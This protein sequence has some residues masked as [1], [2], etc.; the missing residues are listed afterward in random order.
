[1][2]TTL[3]WLGVACGSLVG[4]LAA[5]TL[6][7]WL[8]PSRYGVSQS[9]LLP[10]PVADVWAILDD[11]PGQTAWRR[12]LIAVDRLPDEGSTEVWRERF[13][14]SATRSWTVEARSPAW[15]V[16][17]SDLEGGAIQRRWEFALE[18]VVSPSN[19]RITLTERGEIRNPL[20]RFVIRFIIGRS[21]TLKNLLSD[22]AG[23]FDARPAFIPSVE[24]QRQADAPPV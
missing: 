19:T 4:A 1:M 10:V 7:G 23:R 18:P 24:D 13:E 2:T 5:M 9:F 15:L 6:I 11:Y 21:R 12:D 14:R 22:L 16:R 8:M 20:R 17:Q 3:A